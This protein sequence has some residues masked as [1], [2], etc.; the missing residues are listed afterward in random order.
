MIP[1]HK[2]TQRGINKKKTPNKDD[3]NFDL[4]RIHVLIL[5]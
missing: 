4:Q 3:N 2:Q 1:V 5:Q